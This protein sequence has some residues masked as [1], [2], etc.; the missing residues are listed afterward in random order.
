MSWIQCKCGEILHDITD[1]ISYKGRI[2]SDKQFFPL[3]DLADELIEDN[4]AD[5]EAVAMRFRQNIGGYI[6]FRDIY[7]CYN[8]GRILIEGENGEFLFFMPDGH[9]NTRLLDV[10]TGD[11]S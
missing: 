8:C 10:K 7:Q 2:L 4:S 9:D 6:R 5:R 11:K 1:N 3:L